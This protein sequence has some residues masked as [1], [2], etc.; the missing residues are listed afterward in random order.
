M[1]VAILY[2]SVVQPTVLISQAKRAGPPEVTCSP[3]RYVLVFLICLL[4]E[5]DM[6][7]GCNTTVASRHS[8]SGPQS[9]SLV[10]LDN[11]LRKRVSEP[12]S[13]RFLT[14]PKRIGAF[15]SRLRELSIN[16]SDVPPYPAD[17]AV[18][19]EQFSDSRLPLSAQRPCA[20]V[21]HSSRYD[22]LS[23]FSSCTYHASANQLTGYGTSRGISVSWPD[24]LSSRVAPV[25]SSG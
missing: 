17:L 12:H 20:H 15:R 3:P 13:V 21:G 2:S 5:K 4:V 18:T 14:G 6:C 7:I 24:L 8:K 22:V 1:E 23:S 11:A 10:P 19:G 25:V 9:V 16:V